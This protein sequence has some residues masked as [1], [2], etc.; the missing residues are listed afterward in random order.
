MFI[1]QIY[2]V[3][4]IE[5]VLNCSYKKIFIFSFLFFILFQKY[6]IPLV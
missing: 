4:K 6:S 2:T 3:V 5:K 1:L